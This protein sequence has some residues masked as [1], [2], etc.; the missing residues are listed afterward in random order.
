MSA[1]SITR[2]ISLG[3]AF[4]LCCIGCVAGFSVYTMRNV[5]NIQDK[6]TH[7]FLAAAQFA[8]DFQRE[9]LNAR[10]QLI[11]FITI[12]KP[13]SHDLGLTRLQN[14]KSRLNDLSAV[15]AAHP[16]LSAQQALVVKLSTDLSDY[17]VALAAITQTVD[18]GI[19]QGDL[20][21]AQVKEWAQRGA[22][23]VGDADRAQMVSS[24][25]SNSSNEANLGSL[26]AA[27]TL[28]TI[29]FICSL[30]LCVGVAALIVKRLTRSLRHITESL[31][32]SAH[33]IASSASELSSSANA[34]AQNSSEQASTIE[35]TSAASS[36]IN[37]MAN[38]TTEGS[39]KAFEMVERSQ[40]AFNHTNQCIT[41]MVTSMTTLSASSRK[42]SVVIKVIDD[43]A[44]QTNILALNAAVEAAR[45]GEAGMGFAV[46]A[47][48][49][50]NLA[51]RC[52]QAA[53]DT[54]LLIEE[55]IQGAAAA[56][57]TVDQVAKAVQTI[58]ADSATVKKVVSEINEGSV[59]QTRRIEQINHALGQME[60][61]TQG[62]AAA[63]EESAAAAE[64]LNA[65]ARTMRE[66]V[67]LLKCLVNGGTQADL[68]PDN[69]SPHLHTF[70]RA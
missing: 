32:S 58:T 5:L 6:H 40:T 54:V 36:L 17:D 60:T 7:S 50:R 2:F 47:N 19:L 34:L 3:F 59:E 27:S 25:T 41:D 15:V 20:Y 64:E 48:E 30:F 46:V 31:E 16:E 52:A 8:N 18:H 21:T 55:S 42:I 61:V 23:L 67:D 24:T 22:V 14:A 49:V 62:S 51:Q 70:A 28:D 9:I 69:S 1:W 35:E 45:A 12:Q 44:F 4:M 57:L 26:R 10:I 56:N 37:T 68:Q 13:G 29:T 39:R 33:Q 53:K 11:Y 38:R 63:S 65:Q 66:V 43:I